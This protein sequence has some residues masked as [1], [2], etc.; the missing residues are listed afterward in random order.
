MKS[1]KIEAIIENVYKN[2]RELEYEKNIWKLSAVG[3]K[4][5][6]YINAQKISFLRFNP[7][8]LVN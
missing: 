1:L 6:P 7:L 3:I 8:W 4:A 2:P 5:P